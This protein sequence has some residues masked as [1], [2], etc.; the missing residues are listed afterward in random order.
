MLIDVLLAASKQFVTATRELPTFLI[1]LLREYIRGIP[2]E[3]IDRRTHTT[4]R[5][6][7]SLCVR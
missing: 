1:Q 2:F 7:L 5:H 3:L 6:I 4:S